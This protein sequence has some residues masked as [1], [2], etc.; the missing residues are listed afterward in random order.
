MWMT[1]DVRMLV[2][3]D[4]FQGSKS[5]PPTL[6]PS[7]VVHFRAVP[8][9]KVGQPRDHFQ[10]KFSIETPLFDFGS[11]DGAHSVSVQRKFMPNLKSIGGVAVKRG[12]L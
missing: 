10:L 4:F 5:G 1:S 3:S 9:P 7:C 2:G 8:M 11:D 6:P 12:H